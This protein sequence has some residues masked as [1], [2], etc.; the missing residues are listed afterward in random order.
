METVE[1]SH[2]M[3]LKGEFLSVAIVRNGTGRS[4]T[5][6]HKVAR[7]VPDRKSAV[8]IVPGF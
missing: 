1:P 6:G 5:G 4:H 8:F 3:L 7:P 2:V